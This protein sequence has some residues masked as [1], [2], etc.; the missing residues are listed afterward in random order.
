MKLPIFGKFSGLNRE[1][2]SKILPSFWNSR[3]RSYFKTA[4]IL[5]REFQTSRWNCLFSRSWV[6]FT[7][8]NQTETSPRLL[9]SKIL[10]YFRIAGIL[11]WRSFRVKWNSRFLDYFQTQRGS[12]IQNF[13][14]IFG[15]PEIGS[16]L[17]PREFQAEGVSLLSL[18]LPVPKELCRIVVT[19][20]KL[21][22]DYQNSKNLDYFRI[23]GI[24]IWRVSLLPK[25]TPDF[26]S[27]AILS[28]IQTAGILK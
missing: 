1:F 10:D 26:W 23:A 7:E 4:G 15:I 3:N 28:I 2:H 20:L 16:I 18:K 24:W 19:R 22:R 13:T 14:L 21:P 25:N 12:F 8:S 5:K 27:S 17:K 11:I 9:D 6:G